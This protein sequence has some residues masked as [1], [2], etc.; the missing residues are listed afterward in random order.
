MQVSQAKT[1]IA[2]TVGGI[3]LALGSA[4]MILKMEVLFVILATVGLLSFFLLYYIL[5]NPCGDFIFR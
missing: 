3:L 1:H 2:F 4:F 5:M